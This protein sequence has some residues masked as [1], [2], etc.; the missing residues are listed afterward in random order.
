VSAVRFTLIGVGAA[1]IVVSGASLVTG[2]TN[3]RTVSAGGPSPHDRTAFL[4]FAGV[5]VSSAFIVGIVWATLNAL[6]IDVCGG[7]R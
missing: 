6:F 3:W 7:M 1:A 2:L 4:A 5:F